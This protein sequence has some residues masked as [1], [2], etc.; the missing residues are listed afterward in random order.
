MFERLN[1]GGS[2]S[3]SL[4]DGTY[5]RDTLTHLMAAQTN[6]N[7]SQTHQQA[8]TIAPCCR[9]RAVRFATIGE[10]RSGTASIHNK[11]SSLLHDNMQRSIGGGEKEA[12]GRDRNPFVESLAFSETALQAAL[13]A[14]HMG[15]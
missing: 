5:E 14:V 9:R 15:S 11:C 13:L 10:R 6:T 3:V 7:F 8:W 1:S 2:D 4:K 12:P